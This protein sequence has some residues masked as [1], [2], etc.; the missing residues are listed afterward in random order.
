MD[1]EERQAGLGGEG[2]VYWLCGDDFTVVHIHENFKIAPIFV[3]NCTKIFNCTFSICAID[4]ISIIPQTNCE[5][6][7]PVRVN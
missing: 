6:Y 5:V 3:Q 1:Y 2:Y 4:C 7:A